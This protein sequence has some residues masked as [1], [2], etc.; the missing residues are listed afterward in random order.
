MSVIRK[1]PVVR[2]RRVPFWVSRER[3]QATDWIEWREMDV[4]V[5]G[6]R[7]GVATD[8]ERIVS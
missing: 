7:L 5:L 2:P 8:R 6:S 4:A 1:K 3:R